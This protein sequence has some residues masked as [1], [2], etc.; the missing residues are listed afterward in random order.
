V[1]GDTVNT[2][3]LFLEYFVIRLFTMPLTYAL[4]LMIEFLV[5]NRLVQLAQGGKDVHDTS[6]SF[7]D[8]EGLIPIS[9]PSAFSSTID[10]IISSVQPQD[11]RFESSILK[12][13]GCT[14]FE[15]KTSQESESL[16]T[17]NSLDIELQSTELD[18]EQMRSSVINALE[19]QYLGR[20]GLDTI[21][22]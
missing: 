4:K 2:A 8:P 12:M 20:V 5:L 6:V 18:R 9:N 15:Y 21:N 10:P 7:V 22:R 17:T 13:D 14:V 1:L 3:L 11:V 16:N 19:R